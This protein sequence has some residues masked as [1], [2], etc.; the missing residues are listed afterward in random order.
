MPSSQPGNERL[1]GGKWGKGMGDVQE[2]G[3][4]KASQ[5]AGV[6]VCCK[7]REMRWALVGDSP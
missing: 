7:W 3:E 5:M 1:G 4:S 2:N 6:L